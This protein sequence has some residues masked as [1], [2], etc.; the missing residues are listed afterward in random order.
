MKPQSLP[1]APAPRG[2]R[3]LI[4]DDNP[5]VRRDLSQLLALTG[6]LQ[7]AGEAA[8]GAEALRQAELLHPDVILLDLEMPVMDGY[9]AARQL[10]VRWPGC[11]VVALSV[12]SY[13]AARQKAALAGCDAFIEKGAALQEILMKIVGDS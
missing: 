5:H 10:K 9:S 6:D 3:L 1:S 7:I 2:L 8:D 13:P 12:H 11:R 4:V